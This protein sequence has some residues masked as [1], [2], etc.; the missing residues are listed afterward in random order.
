MTDDP[1]ET[2]LARGVGP[3][4]AAAFIAKVSRYVNYPNML[5]GIAKMPANLALEAAALAVIEDRNLAADLGLDSSP[6]PEADPLVARLD[7]LLS[8]DTT[9]ALLTLAARADI[10]VVDR[11]AGRLGNLTWADKHLETIRRSAVRHATAASTP[12]AVVPDVPQRV[13]EVEAWLAAH[14]DVGPGVLAPYGKQKASSRLAAIRALGEIATPQA[15]E[16]LGQ[17]ASDSYPD[18]VLDE[19]HRA[20]GRFD[21]R[22]FAATM[23]RQAGWRLDLGFGSSIEGIGAASGLIRLK[24]GFLGSADLSPLAECSEL[25]TLWVAS[26]YEPGLLSVSPLL[27]MTQLTELHLSGTMGNADLAQMAALPVRRLDLDLNGVECSFLLE[28]HRLEGLL[29]SGAIPDQTTNDVIVALVRKGVRVA[30]LGYEAEWV[31]R[32]KESAEQ[33]N[34]IFLV[35]ERNRIGLINDESELGQFERGLRYFLS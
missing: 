28:M 27:G 18:K 14:R 4:E 10:E 2:A 17:Y 34:G 15:L 30:V 22:A 7:F 25:E 23:F 29:L 1:I 24:V 11:V 33:E 13:S 31:A 6:V 21:R 9:F 8:M 3:A 35:E 16:V 5:K 26:P 32:L 20:W 19:L 12:Q